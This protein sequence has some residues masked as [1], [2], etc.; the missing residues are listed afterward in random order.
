MRVAWSILKVSKIP[1]K[2]RA[3]IKDKIPRWCNDDSDTIRKR[4][5]TL[6]YAPN[7]EVQERKRDIRREQELNEGIFRGK[8][9]HSSSVK[10]EGSFEKMAA[11]PEMFK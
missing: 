5:L 4:D 10:S 9:S 7:S 1:E 6:A 3:R 8:S 11:S 2:V